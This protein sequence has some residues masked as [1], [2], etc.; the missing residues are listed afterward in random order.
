MGSWPSALLSR[1]VAIVALGVLL[2]A[3]LT[4]AAEKQITAAKPAKTPVA[5]LPADV[6]VVPDV[7][8][9]AYVFAKGILDDNGFAWRVA[10]GAGGYAAN[11]VVG[12]SPAAGTRVIATGAPL[13]TLTLK[14]NP[15][16]AEKGTPE[17]ASPFPASEVRLAGATTAPAAKLPTTPTT[18]AA[19]ATPAATAKPAATT[20]P[21]ATAKPAAR[22]PDFAVPAAPKEPADEMPLIDRA[23]LLGVW[24]ST[25]KTPSAANVRRFL[26]QNA[27]VVTGAKFGWWHGAQAL[28]VLIEVDHRAQSIWGIGAQSESVA[29]AA[30]AKIQ[31][32]AR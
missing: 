14:R 9:Q 15:K 10:G 6:I 23:Q 22:K 13:V 20:K 30:L 26:Y 16:Y 25:H 21:A 28:K 3:T 18:P 12:Q 1:V 29:R 32:G 27:W 19:K 7:S 11:T 24:L 31:A 2:T 4:W 17:N 5:P 8:G